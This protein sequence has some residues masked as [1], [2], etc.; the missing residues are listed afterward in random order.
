[1]LNPVNTKGAYTQLAYAVGTFFYAGLS[2]KAPG[3]MGSIA[4][5]PFVVVFLHTPHFTLALTIGILIA[6][7]LGLWATHVIIKQEQCKDPQK[8]VIDEVVGQWLAFVLIPQEWL[9]NNLWFLLVGLFFFRL[10]DITKTAGI[11]KLESLPGTWGVMMD[12]VLAGIY[13]MIC[14]YGIKTLFSFQ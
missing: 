7:I 10:F 6:T 14:C 2:P 11:K 3:T 12:D 5:L 8:V 13:A 1:M 9:V 4:A